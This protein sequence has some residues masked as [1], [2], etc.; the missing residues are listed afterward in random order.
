MKQKDP[1]QFFREIPHLKA[2]TSLKKFGTIFIR[3]P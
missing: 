3:R 2:K 1:D